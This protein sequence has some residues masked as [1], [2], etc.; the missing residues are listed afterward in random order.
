MPKNWV[1]FSLGAKMPPSKEHLAHSQA[2]HEFA[3][4][5]RGKFLNG[6]NPGGFCPPARRFAWFTQDLQPGVLYFFFYNSPDK[7]T[8]EVVL[9]KPNESNVCIATA[10]GGSAPS[11]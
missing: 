4:E 6:N 1:E 10:S 5:L 11:R 8:R 3:A 9:R 2:L 7:I